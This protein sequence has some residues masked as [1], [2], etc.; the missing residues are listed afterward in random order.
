MP[1]AELVQLEG[2]VVNIQTAGD[3]GQLKSTLL[4]GIHWLGFD[5]LAISVNRRDVSEFT[6]RPDICSH[7][8]SFIGIYR[9]RRIYERDPFLKECM[10]GVEPKWAVVDV[11]HEQ[12]FVRELSEFFLAYNIRSAAFMPLPAKKGLF[13]GM[14]ATGSQNGRERDDILRKFSI[15][16][17]TSMMKLEL[18]RSPPYDQSD[19][20]DR[21][22]LLT[23]Q[24]IE[25]LRWASEGK[26]NTSIAVITGLSKAG[27]DYHFR[28]II[29]KLGVASRTQAVAMFA[30][31]ESEAS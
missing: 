23:E 16:A 21:L 26:S 12:P 14:I 11:N 15:L 8:D 27:I 28:A 6:T 13:S 18:L 7:Q 20:A 24:Q 4:D 31:S 1:D 3:I 25:I 2:Y 9:K 30:R 17:R 5:D 29:S 22:A 10:R 19:K